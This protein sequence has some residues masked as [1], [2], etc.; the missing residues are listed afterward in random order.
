MWL[1]GLQILSDGARSNLIF[2]GGEGLGAE[3]PVAVDAEEMEKMGQTYEKVGRD[4][5]RIGYTPSVVAS[6]SFSRLA[7]SSD[8][9][10]LS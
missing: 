8:I 2:Q 9:Y 7:T 5:F 6:G 3:K 10:L 1:G 4:Q